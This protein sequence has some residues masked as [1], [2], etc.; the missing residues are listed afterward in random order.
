M[1]FHLGNLTAFLSGIKRS[2]A[3]A[4]N[5]QAKTTTTKTP[6]SPASGS[7]PVPV[8]DI[9]PQKQG[10]QGAHPD[11]QG[12][13]RGGDTSDAMETCCLVCRC[14]WWQYIC[15]CGRV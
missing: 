7:S 6:E 8:R 10:S 13:L 12:G 14:D 4:I 3:A 5:T 1:A 9:H 15:C 11:V 2:H